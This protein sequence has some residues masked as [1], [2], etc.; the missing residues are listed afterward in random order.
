MTDALAYGGGGEQHYSI[1]KL[2]MLSD[3]WK[4]ATVIM[5]LCVCV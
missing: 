2:G 5:G 3:L 4:Y 1:L